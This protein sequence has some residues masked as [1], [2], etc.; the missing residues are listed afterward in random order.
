MNI[1]FLVMTSDIELGKGSFGKVYVLTN[2]VNPN[3]KIAMKELGYGEAFNVSNE[4][5]EM[6]EIGLLNCKYVVSLLG[7]DLIPSKLNPNKP[8]LRLFMEYCDKNDLKK[9]YQDK[10]FKHKHI[11]ENVCILFV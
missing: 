2:R 6:K 8:I 10:N 3:I 1:F 5:A 7:M 4:N 9:Y 11:S